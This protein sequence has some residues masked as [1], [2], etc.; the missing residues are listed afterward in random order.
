MRRPRARRTPFSRARRRLPSSPFGTISTLLRPG[1]PARELSP[2]PLHLLGDGASYRVIGQQCERR[3]RLVRRRTRPRFEEPLFD[4][5]F[6]IRV[7]IRRDD[8]VYG[9]QP[10]S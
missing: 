9:D 8:G 2:T 5:Y 10:I 6:F 4:S 3:E 1:R 7:P